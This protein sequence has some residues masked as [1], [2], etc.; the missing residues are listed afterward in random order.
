M[1]FSVLLII[2]L[3]TF[4]PIQSTFAYENM[5]Y[6]FSV[7]PPDGWSIEEMHGLIAVQFTDV[8]TLYDSSSISVAV[9][10]TTDSLSQFISSAKTTFANSIENYNLVSERSRVIGGLDCYEVVVT[11]TYAGRGLKAKQVYFVEFGKSFVITYTAIESQY[12]NSLLDFENSLSTFRITAPQHEDL[13]DNNNLDN[14][15]FVIAIITIVAVVVVITVTLFLHQKNQR[16]R[17]SITGDY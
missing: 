12:E 3:S 9:A 13:G 4:F 1:L 15:I 14:T 6:G 16:K 10:E 17:K 5:E 8:N 2:V 7:N 11:F